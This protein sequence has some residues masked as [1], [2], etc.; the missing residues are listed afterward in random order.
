MNIL[1]LLITIGVTYKSGYYKKLY[2]IVTSAPSDPRDAPDYWAVRGW[3]N[4][5]KKLNVDVDI[6]FFGNSIT[7]FSS[8]EQQYDSLK[9]INLGYPGD[10]IKGMIQRVDMLS[11]CHP[12]KIFLMAG[13]NGLENQTIQ[14][15]SEQYA[16][17]LDSMQK[18]CPASRIYIE[19]ILPINEDIIKEKKGPNSKIRQANL[20]LK[21]YAKD[22]NLIFIDLYSVYCEDGQLPN[23][24]TKDGLHLRPEAYAPWAE[25]ISKYINE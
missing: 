13:I 6:A 15:F 17:L 22:R 12:E 4:T 19:S 8:F 7:Y 2:S 24:Y 18:Q 20:V 21:Q 1:L 23:R 10:N 11:S 16:T 5:I 3:A 14:E 9:I 25:A